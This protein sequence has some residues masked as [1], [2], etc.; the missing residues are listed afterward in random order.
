MADDFDGPELD[1]NIRTHS[2][3]G[4]I[5]ETEK[6]IRNLGDSTEGAA[7]GMRELL[8]NARHSNEVFR[9]LEGAAKGGASGIME[10][11][12][13]LRGFLVIVTESLG[14]TGLGGLVLILGVLGGAFY[15]LT[16]H[17]KETGEE[18]GKTSTRA[19]ELKKAMDETAKSVEANFKDMVE[20]AKALLAEM[21]KLDR[22][23]KESEARESKLRDAK[24]GVASA[25]LD[26]DE[27]NS[28]AAASTPEEAEHIKAV[29]A[30]RRKVADLDKEGLKSQ[31]E[32]LSAQTQAERA[33]KFRGAASNQERTLAAGVSAAQAEADKKTRKA[34]AFGSQLLEEEKTGTPR[35]EE[36]EQQRRKLADEAFAAQAAVKKAQADHDKANEDLKKV[37]GNAD[38][39]N[40][41]LRDAQEVDKANQE[42]IRIEKEVLQ[43]IE[44]GKAN[45]QLAEAAKKAAEALNKIGEKG[46][47]EKGKET[48]KAEARAEDAA[49]EHRDEK[50]ERAVERMSDGAGNLHKA[51]K[52]HAEKTAAH[53]E[54]ATIHLTKTTRDQQRTARQIDNA[55]PFVSP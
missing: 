42:K 39:A 16:R 34:L 44:L 33:E 28:L 17:T 29:Y 10:A 55:A 51:V 23:Q 8:L 9:G 18:L 54:S 49:E 35:T 2:D 48:T 24:A 27:Q 36:Q 11:A 1:I 38:E 12:R 19:E 30:Q 5:R 4:P 26:L 45:D 6:E 32:V 40:S 22:M 47:E 46:K 15:A 21:E 25:Q 37:A 20:G 14:A 52:E 31:N 3:T 41:K 13:G 7:H 43:Q 50:A 53:L